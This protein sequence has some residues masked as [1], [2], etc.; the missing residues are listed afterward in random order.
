MYSLE[1]NVSKNFKSL[2]LEVKNVANIEVEFVESSENLTTG[3]TDH[4]T[5]L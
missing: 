1:K 3:R 2:L 4:L 5:Y